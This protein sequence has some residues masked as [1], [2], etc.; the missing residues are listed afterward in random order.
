MVPEKKTSLISAVV[1][2]ICIIFYI[3]AIVFGLIQII[4]SINSRRVLAQ[5]EFNDLA[6]RASQ[7]AVLGFMSQAYQE[8][9]MDTI[10]ESRT[11]LGAILS[12][13]DGQY[14]FE[15]RQGSVINWVGNSPRFKPG[16]GL[17]D[18]PY[19]KI[20]MINGQ[21]NGSIQVQYSLIDYD[22]FLEALK[23]TLTVILAALAIAVLAL[24]IEISM[25]KRALALQSAAPE[26]S[27]LR[28]MPQNEP[29]IAAHRAMQRAADK[30]ELKDTLIFDDDFPE[31]GNLKDRLTPKEPYDDKN[32]H[33]LFSSRSSVGWESYTRDRLVSELHRCA[34]SEQDLVFLTIEYSGEKNPLTDISLYRELAHEVAKFFGL[35][36]LIFEKGEYGFSVI[37]PNVDLEQGIKKSEEFLR[38]IKNRLSG[39]FGQSAFCIGLSSRSGRLVEPERLIFESHEALLKAK[40]DPVS[41][42]I[43]FKSDPDKY[44][45]YIS[46]HEAA[47]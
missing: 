28:E 17:P 14:G 43:G 46:R 27:P 45:K 38:R 31:S 37:I 3:T 35:R 34:L 10:V 18:D 36:D 16:F 25:K 23:N 15:R 11:I 20:I 19:H 42:I 40:E 6:D 26:P 33:G 22:V 12:G 2:S 21:R 44:R 41:P 29:Y 30:P 32:P 5:Q 13:S 9:L 39:S 24:I 7:A 47:S 8:S 4:L 1:A